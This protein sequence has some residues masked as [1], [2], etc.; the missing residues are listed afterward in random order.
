MSHKINKFKKKNLKFISLCIL[1]FEPQVV[2]PKKIK[3]GG[4]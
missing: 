1:M 2:D 3:D 4:M